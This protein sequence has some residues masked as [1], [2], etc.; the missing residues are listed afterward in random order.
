MSK[1]T[2]CGAEIAPG[3][4]FCVACG[5]PAPVEATPVTPVAP[6][7]PAQPE[8]AQAAQP[9]GQTVQNVANQAGA[10]ANE[11]V[12]KVKSDKKVRNIVIAVAAAVLVVIIAIVLVAALRKPYEKVAKKF[13]NAVVTG[14]G[15]QVVKCLPKNVQQDMEVVTELQQEVMEM[16]AEYKAYKTKAK[17]IYSVQVFDQVKSFNDSYRAQEYGLMCEKAYK[18]T[19][20]LKNAQRGFWTQD[21]YVGKINGKWAIM[22]W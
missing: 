2:N 4:K 21:V 7:A 5:T 10:K 16:G 15:K 6:V 22:N 20:Q 17:L 11:L 18:C 3:S 1:C 8:G 9:V 13:A 14:N 19:F 12:G